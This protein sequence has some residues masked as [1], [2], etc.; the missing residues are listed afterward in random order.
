MTDKDTLTHDEY[1]Y[2][3]DELRWTHKQPPKTPPAVWWMYE[4]CRAMEDGPSSKRHPDI[5]FFYTQGWEMR[6][7]ERLNTI[8]RMGPWRHPTYTAERNLILTIRRAKARHDF[9]QQ[10]T[11]VLQQDIEDAKTAMD[12]LEQRLKEIQIAEEIEEDQ[13]NEKQEAFNNF[14]DDGGQA[15][16]PTIGKGKD[17][18][19]IFEAWKLQYRSSEEEGSDTT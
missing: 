6:L 7:T 19:A 8:D 18:E 14:I 10:N 17:Y 13:F 16:Q 11:D 3:K 2:I 15:V 5:A 4:G 12:T 1:H 9:L